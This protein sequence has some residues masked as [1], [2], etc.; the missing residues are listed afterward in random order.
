MKSFVNIIAIVCPLLL[1]ACAGTGS[2]PGLDLDQSRTLHVEVPSVEQ[3]DLQL[4]DPGAAVLTGTAMSVAGAAGGA[5]VGATGGL[6]LGATC[7]PAWI[8]CGPLYA[9]AGAGMLGVG[10]GAVGAKYGGKGYIAGDKSQRF[11]ERVAEGYE[12]KAVTQTLYDH[13]LSAAARRWQIDPVSE[14][15]ITLNIS[16]LR[17]EQLTEQRIRIVVEGEMIAEIDGTTRRF[18]VRHNGPDLHIDSWLA[19]DGRMIHTAVNDA[20]E[21]VSLEVISALARPD[22]KTS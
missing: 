15:S 14:N 18:R 17:A 10:G 7:G 21:S 16:R 2:R 8:I 1:S 4:M 22:Q 6:L 5:A 12:P 11:N 19:H 3:V 9:A 20:L 13:L